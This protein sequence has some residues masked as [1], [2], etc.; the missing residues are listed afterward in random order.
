MSDARLGEL[1]DATAQRDAIHIAIAPVVASQHLEPGEHVG[2]MP[3][4]R[5]GMRADKH[6]GIVDP[7]LPH[8]VDEGERFYL[9]LYQQTVTGMRHH[10]SHPDFSK[11]AQTAADLPESEAWLRGFADEVGLSY[12][13]LLEAATN[14]IEYGDYHVFPYDTP[15]CCYGSMRTFW[16]HIEAVTGKRPQDDDSHPFCCSC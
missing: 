7:F 4:G 1:L 9:C 3:D 14:Y 5:V 12:G 16:R 15:D 11:E 10:W 2:F 6:I 13:K 8:G